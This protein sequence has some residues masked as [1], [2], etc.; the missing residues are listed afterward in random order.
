M[1]YR[2]IVLLCLICIVFIGF[3]AHGQFVAAAGNTYYVA[4]NGNDANAGTLAAPWL[5]ITHAVQTMT[6]GSICY[7]EAG[8][9]STAIS[10]VATIYYNGGGG[11]SS[12]G[13]I[14]FENYN[15]GAVN[16]IPPTND[17]GIYL[18]GSQ[19][20]QFIGL[21]FTC[22]GTSDGAGVWG[23]NGCNYIVL[24][25]CTFTGDAWGGIIFTGAT[26]TNL[27]ITGCTCNKNCSTNVNAS[28]VLQ[29][30]NTFTINHCKVSNP[31]YAARCCIN[32]IASSNG[33]I[34]DNTVFGATSMGIYVNAQIGNTSNIS[35]YDN[36]CYDNLQ[37]G[38]D[39]CSE[40][41]TY[42]ISNINIYNNVIYGNGRGFRV[43]E[44]RSETYNFSFINNTLYNNDSAG[45]EIYITSTPPELNNCIIRNNIIYS[46]TSGVYAIDLSGDPSSTNI[47]IDHNLFYNSSGSWNSTNILGISYL[48]GNPL[49]AD[50]TANFALQ[51]GSIAIGAGSP[52]DAPTTD[53]IGA[54]RANQ[55]CI[56]AYEYQT[57][58]SVP[59][60]VTTTG[61]FGYDGGTTAYGPTAGYIHFCNPG[62]SG[63]NATPTGM[64]AMVSNT[65]TVAHNVQLAIYTLSVS[66][67]TLVSSTGTIAVP[68][69]AAG[70]WVTGNFTTSPRLS[71]STTYYLG[72]ETD[73]TAIKFWYSASTSIAIYGQSASFDSWPASFSGQYADFLGQIGVLVN[74]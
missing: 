37:G 53:Y 59:P 11:S 60:T 73:N 65:D 19:Y 68:A 62:Y 72:I 41:G 16:I 63:V 8:T 29:N 4:T 2:I 45:G 56:G 17:Y 21:N 43:D 3:G 39:L 10:K 30:C 44:Y 54:T 20:L 6:A 40:S 9:Y 23:E 66:T 7:I 52:T 5:T 47:T 13:Y 64:S 42:A 67:Y 1:K 49:L 70:I 74:Y 55:P 36:L 34:Y 22:S 48:K 33:T 46:L 58:A 24:Q 18:E 31:I 15:G 51:S 38:I 32:P 25:N 35:I 71:S 69:G 57:N 12:G 50:P 27:T 26:D 14:T 61:S 28:I